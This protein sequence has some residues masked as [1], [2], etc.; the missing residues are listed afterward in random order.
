MEEKPKR[1]RPPK[2]AGS[3]RAGWVRIRL[4]PDELALIRTAAEH[5]GQTVSDWARDRLLR[6]GRRQLGR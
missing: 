4:T 5:A 2:E 6:A 1:G 3:V